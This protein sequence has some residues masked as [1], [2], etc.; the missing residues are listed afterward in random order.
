MTE[1]D[2]I[3]LL[4]EEAQGYWG[5]GVFLTV[6]DPREPWSLTQWAAYY[7][8]LDPIKRG[9][10]VA[11]PTSR[12]SWLMESIKKAA[13]LQLTHDTHLVVCQ[14]SPMLLI[15]NPDRMTPLIKGLPDSLKVYAVQI[16]D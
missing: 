7:G 2:R 14:P 15:A 9:D 6:D 1:R 8:G 16:Q 4:E 10:L 11:I 3:K 12:L 13:C 5:P